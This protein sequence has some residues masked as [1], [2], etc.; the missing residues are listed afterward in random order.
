MTDKTPQPTL[1]VSRRVELWLAP[2][3]VVAQA[4]CAAAVGFPFGLGAA[5]GMRWAWLSLAVLPLAAYVF[6]GAAVV[7]DLEDLEDADAK[8]S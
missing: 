7:R 6:V 2:R 4:V 1:D 3:W 5:F 8:S